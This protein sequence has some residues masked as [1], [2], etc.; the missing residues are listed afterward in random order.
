MKR[1]TIGLTLLFA[2][3]NTGCEDK[4]DDSFSMVGKWQGAS[5][6]ESTGEW[7]SAGD[8]TQ[9]KNNSFLLSGG[10]WFFEIDSDGNLLKVN[11]ENQ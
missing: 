6:V 8:I 11:N 2:L 10:R 1:Y 9:I 4:K 5:K 3:I 7:Q